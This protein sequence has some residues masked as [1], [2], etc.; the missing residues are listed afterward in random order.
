MHH[1]QTMTNPANHFPFPLDHHSGTTR[2]ETDR[3]GAANQI[4]GK[5]TL[6]KANQPP[7]TPTLSG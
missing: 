7:S 5:S 6:S 4:S 1:F 3:T 2:P